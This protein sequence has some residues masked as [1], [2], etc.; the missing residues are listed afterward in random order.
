MGVLSPNLGRGFCQKCKP[1][2]TYTAATQGKE[3]APGF[4][5]LGAFA[6]CYPPHDADTFMNGL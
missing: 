1:P 4:C 2:P 3:I 6:L 5:F